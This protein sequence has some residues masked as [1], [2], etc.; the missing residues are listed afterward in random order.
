MKNKLREVPPSLPRLS[1]SLLRTDFFSP[2]FLSFQV[3]VING[4][5]FLIHITTTSIYVMML[6]AFSI[7]QDSC[8]KHQQT[9][10]IDGHGGVIWITMQSFLKWTWLSTMLFVPQLHR[11]LLQKFK[12]TCIC[13]C[14]Q[15][16]TDDNKQM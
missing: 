5:R 6:T 9:F 10:Q 1:S 8:Y 11:I 15:D 7:L 3:L 16:G 13:C 2:H 12:K 14:L 4:P